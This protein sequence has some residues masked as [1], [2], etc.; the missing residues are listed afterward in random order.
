MLI[1]AF[2]TIK[3]MSLLIVIVAA[4]RPSPTRPYHAC[5]L[6][7]FSASCDAK[8]HNQVHHRIRLPRSTL[9][10]P[11]PPNPPWSTSTSPP[12]ALP[13][14]PSSPLCGPGRGTAP[15]SSYHGPPPFPAFPVKS[16]PPS[17]PSAPSPH[18]QVPRALYP[19]SPSD[20]LTPSPPPLSPLPSSLSPVSLLSALPVSLLHLRCIWLRRSRPRYMPICPPINLECWPPFPV[21]SSGNGCFTRL[22]RL[23]H[24]IVT[25]S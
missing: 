21:L 23:S 9:H 24:E 18:S 2:L 3:K 7:P 1:T 8:L 11:P 15:P 22:H 13:S 20:R 4:P 14:T 6:Y 19:L 5:W 25:S 10:L 12:L 16:S 17:S